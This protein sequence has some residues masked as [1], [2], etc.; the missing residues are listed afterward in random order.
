MFLS[1]AFLG[2]LA[3]SVSGLVKLLELIITDN[4]YSKLLVIYLMSLP[5]ST[6]IQGGYVVAAILT[7]AVLGL[8][9]IAFTEWTEGLGGL[10]GGFSFSMWLLTLKPGGLLEGTGPKV[11][12]ICALCAAFYA[13]SFIK[14]VRI[15]VLI[16][17]IAF[18]GA[19]ALMLGIDCFTRVGLK[20]FWLY[21]WGKMGRVL[22]PTE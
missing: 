12:L 18:S 2:G 5:V 10:L 14:H 9:S 7:G 3:V 20:E 16:A 4:E 15:Y 13:L 21:I 6:G 8:F 11:G 19:T 1:A 17:N 22:F